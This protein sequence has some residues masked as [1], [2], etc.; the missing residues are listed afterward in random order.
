MIIEAIWTDY[1][2][3][4]YHLPRLG[5]GGFKAALDGVLRK[6]AIGSSSNIGSTVIGKPSALSYKYAEEIIQRYR[7]QVLGEDSS[8]KYRLRRIYMIGDNPESVSY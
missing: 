1:E 7:K 3:Q 8:K 5:Q 2:L 4:A 6:L